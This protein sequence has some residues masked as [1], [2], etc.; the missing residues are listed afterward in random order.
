MGK[1]SVLT[2]KINDIETDL[3]PVT[4]P[5]G[6]IDP[7]DKLPLSNDLHK[8][9]DKKYIESDY[10]GLG[11]CFLKRS[12]DSDNN[13]L[14]QDMLLSENTVYVLE[15]DFDLNG[16]TITI[17]QNSVLKF[18][19][20]SLYN[21]T[22][23]GQNTVIASTLNKIFDTDLELSGSFNIEAWYPEWFGA[24]SGN[25]SIMSTKAI[26]SALNAAATNV[27]VVKL[28]GARYYIDDTLVVRSYWTLMGAS[29]SVHHYGGCTI[30]QTVNKDAIRLSGS[31]SDVTNVWQI[32]L[33]DFTVYNAYE[34]SDMSNCGIVVYTDDVCTY[35]YH[36]EIENVCCCYFDAGFKYDG[37]GD[38]AF[39]YNYFYCLNCYYNKIGFYVKCNASS[40]T[41]VTKYPWVNLNRWSFCKF[42]S[43]S[44][45][46]IY[47]HNSRSQQEN[48]FE[49]C[50][51]EGNG[52]DYSL[53]DY[54]KY[55]CAGWGFR[56]N[57]KA[58]YGYTRFY[59]CYVEGNF[60]RRVSSLDYDSNK[61]YVYNNA[62][63][64]LDIEEVTSNSA[65]SC[66]KQNI[67]VSSCLLSK[68]VRLYRGSGEFSII[69]KNNDYDFGRPWYN[70]LSK[71]TIDHF[72]YFDL[73]LGYINYCQIYIDENFPKGDRDATNT[74]LN[75]M[76]SVFKLSEKCNTSAFRGLKLYIKHPLVDGI[77]KINSTD[78]SN[79]AEIESGTLYIGKSS[80]SDPI[81][82]TKLQPVGS[83]SAAERLSSFFKDDSIV[84]F[85]L[86][87]NYSSTSTDTWSGKITHDI[88]LKGVDG[89][90]YTSSVTKKIYTNWIIDNIIFNNNLSSWH[91]LFESYHNRIEFRNCTFN[92]NNV[93]QYVVRL[94]YGGEIIFNNCSFNV[95][96]DSAG[97][98]I[99]IQHPAYISSTITLCNCS[100]QEGFTIAKQTNHWHPGNVVHKN[101]GEVVR[102][103]G[104]GFCIY[105]GADV[106]NPDGTLYDNARH[107]KQFSDINTN[108]IKCYKIVK[109]IDLNGESLSL[110]WDCTL[111]FQGGKFI[112]GSIALNRARLL[113]MGM[114]M[115]YYIDSSNTTVE[116][117]FWATGQTIYDTSLKQQKMWN[118][119]S[120]VNPDG[121][122]IE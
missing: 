81:G 44:I 75:Q 112:N 17:P 106:I 34:E 102:P 107:V 119:S 95:E 18:E 42:M 13:I 80:D 32:C 52:K 91:H 116:G 47:F 41:S 36:T 92:L 66:Y 37:Y 100:I 4:I 76:K 108:T 77:I 113:P 49:S 97:T 62:V 24:V 82:L 110:P 73:S 70:S 25:D 22:I 121:S 23:K 71:T 98:E 31:K 61:E 26:Q 63:Y 105:D 69:F 60:P 8:I 89:V 84:N 55:G 99:W 19:G 27:K 115:N 64:P 68:Y 94:M 67:E 15:Y 5:Q 29:P 101:P 114:P 51:I 120:W 1:L 2:G 90:E 59:N 46:G 40:D 57:N 58:C 78:S 11:R 87:D 21:G 86:L 74:Y 96:D 28:T 93:D 72:F 65:F 104:K 45:G 35:F 38:G 14:T 103:N 39:A 122:N 56:G 50:A 9:K 33:K 12:A 16:Q 30:Y 83:F 7:E 109:D 111:D 48:I 85:T 20:G 53:V 54:E 6:I 118:G 43:N 3:Y 79:N 88:Y 117:E 10:S